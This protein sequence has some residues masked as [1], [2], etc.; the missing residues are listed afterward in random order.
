MEPV[1]P[2]L[3][4]QWYEEYP[5]KWIEFLWIKKPLNRFKNWL[6]KKRFNSIK[7][8]LG[9][10]MIVA[11]GGTLATLVT[12]LYLIPAFTNETSKDY[13]A[14][15]KCLKPLISLDNY[16]IKM[17]NQGGPNH[18]DILTAKIISRDCDL[19]FKRVELIDFNIDKN[20]LV[21]ENKG[22]PIPPKIELLEVEVPKPI[23]GAGNKEMLI[24]IELKRTTI[25]KGEQ[26]A[27]FE[28]S[29]KQKIG[30]LTFCFFY[31]VNDEVLVDTLKSEILI[32]EKQSTTSGFKL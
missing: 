28:V 10:V 16:R 5:E 24:N 12:V 31:A 29:D 22:F 9:K 26:E 6:K 19:I 14:V 30:N 17:T 18:L 32:I 21:Y 11:L 7:S 25:F 8:F 23:V 2:S 15:D 20:L 27:Y 1:D 13:L 4:N 3:G